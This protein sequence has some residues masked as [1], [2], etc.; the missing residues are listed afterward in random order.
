MSS[1]KL[2]IMYKQNGFWLCCVYFGFK[3]RFISV[4]VVAG[5]FLSLFMFCIYRF[6]S[7]LPGKALAELVVGKCVGTPSVGKKVGEEG[8]GVGADSVGKAVGADSVGKGE[9]AVGLCVGVPSVG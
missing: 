9:G 1:S 2:L 5:V 4:F 7:F 3:F 6:P 8:A